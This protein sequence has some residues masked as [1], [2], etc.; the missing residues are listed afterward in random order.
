MLAALGN[1]DLDWARVSRLVFTNC[2]S[3]EHFPPK[4]FA[5]LVRLCRLSGLA[6]AA[7]LK[8]L[9]TGPG[10]RM[11]AN[12][13]T[14][15][16]IDK[17]RHAAIFGGFLTSAQVRREAV[18]FTADLHP[19]YTTAAATAITNWPKPVLLVWGD[20]DKLVSGEP[21]AATRRRVR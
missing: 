15:D 14:R 10:R 12:S 21:R 1:A 19:R 16:G 20:A 6:G 13:V 7:V 9:T 18:R 2:D 8:L 3:Y 4:G 17:Q 5:P 11:F